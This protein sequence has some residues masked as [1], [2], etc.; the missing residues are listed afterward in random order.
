MSWPSSCLI[1]ASVLG[2]CACGEPAETSVSSPSAA[3]LE[4]APTPFRIKFVGA[5]F[6]E[7][8]GRVVTAVSSVMTIGAEPV[9]CRA[10]QTTTIDRGAFTVRVENRRDDAVYPR[11]GVFVDNNANGQCDA[12]TDLVWSQVTTA[13]PPEREDSVDIGADS[14]AF[15]ADVQG[16]A[17]LR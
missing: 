12:E 2:V 17:L 6:A 8:D 9:L 1:V 13:V 3:C 15:I 5:G 7:L 11:I 16:C 14:L 4:R 10:A